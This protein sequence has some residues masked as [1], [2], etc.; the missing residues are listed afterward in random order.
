MSDSPLTSWA[1]EQVKAHGWEVFLWIGLGG[2]GIGLVV[3]WGATVMKKNAEIKKLREDARKAS[4]DNVQKLAQVRDAASSK[5][6]VL[7]TAKQN[8]RDAL[9][10]DRGG[11]GN[12]TALRG[13]RDEM[14]NIY[15]NEYLPAASDYAQLIPALVDAKEALIRARTE[16]IPGLETICGFLDMVNMKEMLD[17]IPGSQPYKVNRAGRD[18]LLLRVK[19]LVPW[20]HFKLRGKISMVR[21]RTDRHLRD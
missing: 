5:R 15:Q 16:L 10:A 8:M 11:A 7:D 19:T 14:C 4:G 21:K 12:A 17:K 18:G 13:C 6:Q 2:V 20:W 1:L 3:G 9:L